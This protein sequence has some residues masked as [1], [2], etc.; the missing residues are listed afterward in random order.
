MSRP[1]SLY[2]ARRLRSA[3][4]ETVRVGRA[5]ILASMV[6]ASSAVG[7]QPAAEA[8]DPFAPVELY[9]SLADQVQSLAACLAEQ[10]KGVSI[11]P[12]P[13]H[14]RS[15][16]S[17]AF[18]AR[19]RRLLRA[20]GVE[21]YAAETEALVTAEQ[22]LR[23]LRGF[24][25][26]AIGEDDPFDKALLQLHAM[27]LLLVERSRTMGGNCQPADAMVEAMATIEARYRSS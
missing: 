7:A 4:L 26:E 15:L 2:A 10:A 19:A 1:G 20:V 25:N 6:L 11:D 12:R 21:P 9:L 22:V 3:A 5:S 17:P 27:A 18:L 14:D 23:D 24:A 13:M 16:S 8:I